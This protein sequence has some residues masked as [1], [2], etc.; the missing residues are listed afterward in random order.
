MKNITLTFERKSNTVWSD[1][2]DYYATYVHEPTK[3]KWKILWQYS[4]CGEHIGSIQKLVTTGSPTSQGGERITWEYQGE[5]FRFKKLEQ[6]LKVEIDLLE[7][8]ETYESVSRALATPP[9]SLESEP[10]EERVSFEPEMPNL[11][12]NPLGWA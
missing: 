4:Q 6:G 11:R 7:S 10:Q 8:D 2:D 5:V 12:E 1:G 3:S 9:P